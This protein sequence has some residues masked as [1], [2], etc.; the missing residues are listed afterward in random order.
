MGRLETQA[1]PPC[2]NTSLEA[3]A[4]SSGSVTSGALDAQGQAGGHHPLPPSRSQGV[5]V[6]T[7]RAGPPHTIIK[8]LPGSSAAREKSIRVGDTL[9]HVNEVAI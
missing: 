4:K 2:G 6:C 5:C 3:T 9:T 7:S 1:F 8:I